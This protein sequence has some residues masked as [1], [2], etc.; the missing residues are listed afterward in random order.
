MK[1]RRVGGTDSCRSRPFFSVSLWRQRPFGEEN[2]QENNRSKPRSAMMVFHQIQRRLKSS[3]KLWCCHWE[4]F[5][6]N[7]HNALVCFSLR[8]AVFI[9]KRRA[10]KSGREVEGFRE[11]WTEVRK[12]K[13]KDRLEEKAS[14][15]PSSSYYKD[16][17]LS[18]CLKSLLTQ[19]ISNLKGKS[20]IPRDSLQ[21]PSLSA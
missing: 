19:I 1:K 14:C 4:T 5:F 13:E 7:T 3:H 18:F 12:R 20:C 21:H 2:S 8:L 11:R 6:L 16:R 17:S 15:D 10:E 9:V